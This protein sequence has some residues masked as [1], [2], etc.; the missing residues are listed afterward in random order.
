MVL[1]IGFLLPISVVLAI[2][3][4][5]AQTTSI[6]NLSYPTG[7]VPS[8]EAKVTFDVIYSGL[9]SSTGEILAAFVYDGEAKSYAT[10]TGSSTPDQCF[11]LGATQ[12]GDKAVCAWLLSSSS[13]TEHLTFKL[14]FSTH[15]K[16]Y[17]LSAAAGVATTAGQAIYSSLSEQKFSITAGSQVQLTVNTQA[18]VPVT[19]DGSQVGKGTTSLT[20][21]PGTH[22]IS[23]PSIVPIDDLNRLKFE[24][25]D[26]ALNLPTRSVD[27]ESDT[28]LTATYV[29]QHK[30]ILT[31][32]VNAT[33]AGWYDDGSTA[34]FSVP[35]SEPIAGALGILGGKLQFKG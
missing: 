31:S 30:L 26:D 32:P 1:L 16:T 20:L 13:G 15:H 33:G 14:Q 27:V 5:Q 19:V 9:S 4:V 25:W 17:S 12:F 23:V 21:D 24:N 2:P 28:S 35:A 3:S 7:P 10:G 22:S 18:T 6:T 8:G 11:P 29:T 34:R